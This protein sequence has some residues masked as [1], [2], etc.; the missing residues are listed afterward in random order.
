MELVNQPVVIDNG[1]GIIKAG[2]AGDSVPKCRF[3]NYVGRPKH[4]RVMAGAFEGDLLIGPKAE[5]HRGLLAIKYRWNMASSQ[6]G[7]TWRE[8]GNT[9]TA[10]ISCK[11]LLKSPFPLRKRPSIRA[12]TGKSR[13][14]YFS[15]R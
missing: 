6:I 14:R 8:F 9:C 12:G 1:Y 5:E 11:H 4:V 3:P 13:P 7:T 10:K 15:K 2:F